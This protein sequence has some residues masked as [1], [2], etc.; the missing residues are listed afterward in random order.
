MRCSVNPVLVYGSVSPI[1]AMKLS[2]LTLAAEPGC[3]PIT[4]EQWLAYVSDSLEDQHGSLETY[5]PWH[6]PV[7]FT[8]P[9]LTYEWGEY[10]SI[11]SVT[12][13]GKRTLSKLKESGYRLE[14]RLSL[15]GQKVTGFTSSQLFK[16]PDGRLLDSG[17]IHA[18]K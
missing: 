6:L 2:P 3:V 8:A 1:Q 16:L 15:G 7:K 10:S 14:G 13:Y 17:I 12:L 11:Q 9:C 5:G 18:R 4:E